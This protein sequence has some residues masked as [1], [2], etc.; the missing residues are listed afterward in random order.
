VSGNQWKESYYGNDAYAESDQLLGLSKEILW[1][2]KRLQKR[3]GTGRPL[4]AFHAKIRL[5]VR[6]ARLEV[7]S[8]LDGALAV[9]FFQAGS[10]HSCTVRLSN[11]SGSIQPDAKRDMRGI[12]VRIAV[13]NDEHHDLLLTNGPV[14]HARDG[15]E[16]VAFARALA[17][18]KIALPFRLA[19][20]VGLRGSIRIFK[21]LKRFARAEI[22]SLAQETYWSR[23][24]MRWGDQCGRLKLAPVAG[25]GPTR[26]P[27]SHPDYLRM[28]LAD[29]L[30]AGD[31]AF[32][33]FFQRYVD[34]RQTPV[35]DAS[36]EWTEQA[37]P[38]IPIARLII[39]RQDLDSVEGGATEAAV[40]SLA[41]NPWNSTEEFRPLGHVNRARK[42]VYT[43][44]S[45]GRLEYRFFG[46]E[47]LRNRVLGALT[48]GLFRVVNRFVEW[49]RLP[50]LL[51]VL[52]LSGFRYVLRLK[53]LYDTE[54][55]EAPP[56]TQL[57]PA[58]V[59][60]EFR[61]ARTLDGSYN[62][63][64]VP[65]MGAG[66]LVGPPLVRGSTF[67]RNVPYEAVTAVPFDAS[68]NPWEVSER[69]L[70]RKV[71]LPAKSL[72]MIAAAW[73]QF[74]VHDWVDHR[75][76]KLGANGARSLKLPLPG[77]RTWRNRVDGPQE[78]FMEIA[79]NV[80][81][82]TTDPRLKHMPVFENA[83]TPWWDAGQIYGYDPVDAARLRE[84]DGDRLRGELR[85][86]QGFL[87]AHPAPHMAGIEDTGFNE[88]WWLGLS[89]MHTLF[90]REHNA[91]VAA[92]RREYP[93][94]EEDAYYRTGRLVVAALI[95]KIHT[96]E[97][98][99]AILATKTIDI[100]LKANWYG[101]PKD[102][103]S[104]LGIWLTD[105]HAIKGI[106]ET[107]PDHHAA[108]YS[109]TEEFATVYRMHPL[110]PDDFAFF[111]HLDG[112]P[113][114]ANSAEEPATNLRTFG[115][116]QGKE[117]AGFMRKLGLS[118]VAYSFGL[119]NPGAITLQN[120]PRHLREFTRGNGERI[121]LSVVD[122]VRERTRGLPRY[123][124]FRRLLHRP[125]VRDFG[126][127]TSNTEW[128]RELRDLYGDVE[129]IDTMVGLLAE[130][131]PE[132]FGF[133]DTAFRV[134]ILMASRRLQSDRFLNVDFRPEVY[135]PLGIDWV[136]RTGMKEIIERHCPGVARFMPRTESAFA[137]W[138]AA[139]T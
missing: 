110:I 67:G 14:S 3:N 91:I 72:N 49:H 84:R 5:G 83:N 87:P 23:G 121:D 60:E 100:S 46:E 25:A 30:R 65:K 2:Q 133:S 34:E 21:N 47:P 26:P 107:L 29:R 99:P 15:K 4:R 62:D 73:I 106:P 66:E 52:N 112:K 93:G 12:A 41:F 138:R 88:N 64:S 114:A 75:R 82:T 71:F 94:W 136:S 7:R 79:D 86:E 8:D 43:A 48:R 137:P 20:G 126:E 50:T 109:L 13:S 120:Y 127:I 39:P 95:A 134:F 77:G 28:E 51:S 31:V 119:A 111:R 53:N 11:A 135:S 89:L 35:E 102:W 85:L 16:F 45:A 98:T 6:N 54:D 17:G 128:A 125:K 92:L 36:V 103:L 37:S 115:Q 70:A 69:L 44:G 108:P 116:I 117:T 139:G 81:R 18:R 58:P 80:R 78:R 123:N 56:K 68:P 22:D 96:V 129:K 57:L 104:Q 63:L 19:V 105:V 1:I 40:D 130:N 101:A 118:D 131:P 10:S 24:A 132:G 42:A 33:L 76:F 9:G 59:P 38:P 124:E 90:V 122:L 74:Q 32:D 113:A 61:V 27:K 97:W 55:R